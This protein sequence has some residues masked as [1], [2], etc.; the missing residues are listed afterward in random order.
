[1]IPRYEIDTGGCDR[2]YCFR[3]D[4][5]GEVCMFDDVEA[6]EE[7]FDKALELLNKCYEMLFRE[8]PESDCRHPSQWGLDTG[9]AELEV[10][11]P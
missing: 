2:S 10:V 6:L 5:Y 8:Y 3:R 7:K 1:M 4:K 9:I 11:E